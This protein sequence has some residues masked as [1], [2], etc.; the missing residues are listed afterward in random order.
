MT[1]IK[2]VRV[3][4][5]RDARRECRIYVHTTD[6]RE[7]CY[8]KTGNRWN[9]A[10]SID[11][12]LTDAEWKEARA[13]SIYDGA[14][15]SLYESDIHGTRNGKPIKYMPTRCPDC[16]G[17]DCGGGNC[18]SNRPSPAPAGEDYRDSDARYEG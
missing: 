3:W 8:Y 16:G 1:S 5:S 9:P 14:W 13:L 11:G 6:G 7:G 18:N 2:D 10:N 15:H 17:Y 12:K 4:H